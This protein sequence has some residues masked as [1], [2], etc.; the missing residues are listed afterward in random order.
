ME[1]RLFLVS[2]AVIG[3]T[4]QGHSRHRQHVRSFLQRVL[5]DANGATFY[6]LIDSLT[7]EQRNDRFVRA[8]ITYVVTAQQ[9]I[10]FQV[11]EIGTIL[12]TGKPKD[13]FKV[14]RILNQPAFDQDNESLLAHAKN[15]IHSMGFLSFA[16]NEDNATL[17]RFALHQMDRIWNNLDMASWHIQDA[18]NAEYYNDEEFQ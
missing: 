8:S 12:D 16:I 3:L 1:R 13:L 7:D 6:R 18:I 2:G 15:M 11:S 10:T 5:R 14:R 4:P 9:T 17:Y